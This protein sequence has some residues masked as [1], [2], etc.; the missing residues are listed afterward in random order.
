VLATALVLRLAWQGRE[1]GLASDSCQY[2]SIARAVAQGHGF[3]SGGSQHPDLSRP[4]VYPV[5]LAFIAFLVPNAET[6]AWLF[7]ALASALSIW[8]LTILARDFFGVRAG[9][10]AAVLGTFSCLVAAGARFLPTAPFL[11]LC[12]GAA[13]L[14]WR[15]VRS[16]RTNVVFIA[17][18]LCGLAA[19]TRMEGILW[20][21][22][23]G[24]WVL[25]ASPGRLGRRLV[26]TVWLL[27]GAAM[28]YVPYAGWASTRLGRPVLSPGLEYLRLTRVVA[29]SLGLRELPGSSLDWAYNA[30]VALT[31]DHRD[32]V[33]NAAFRDGVL[34]ESDRESTNPETARAAAEGESVLW[35][36][37]RRIVIVL[38][39]LRELPYAIR[40]THFAPIPIVLL[41]AAG[42]VRSLITRRQ[43][44]RLLFLAVL[45]ALTL[46]PV[47]SH[48]EARFLYELFAV[49]VL[50]AANGWAWIDRCA[51]LP[52]LR[53]LS[54][55][56]VTTI[57]LAV[58]LGHPLGGD[59]RPER[60][61]FLRTE[62]ARVQ[63]PKGAM[64]AVQP[65]FP[66]I[67]GR[68]YRAIPLGTPEDVLEYGLANGAT[69]LVFEGD[70]D[71][72]RRPALS[73]LLTDALPNGF[74][75]LHSEPYPDGGE[76]RVF[77]IGR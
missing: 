50:F 29:D 67:A 19:L 10:L 54:R 64:M 53:P 31:A 30:R 49:Q 3:D 76:L 5:A 62:A 21:P 52:Y 43:R 4:P 6:A 68:R 16:D 66:F 18:T 56:A 72:E 27:A 24:M 34:P 46:V 61:A 14:V 71:L 2:L 17:G 9:I 60:I 70:R 74:R 7:A 42:V 65:Q 22:A 51:R 13:A 32:L 1:S 69:T 55:V 41:A 25:V 47:A 73:A 63:L 40:A 39:N 37:A 45:T 12:L 58:G 15:G 48:I 33:L 11:V 59:P 36:S 35:I 38:Q 75:L 8:P 77:A 57:V 44:S 20:A 28:V 23:F 26:L